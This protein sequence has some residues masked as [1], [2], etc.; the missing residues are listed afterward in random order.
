ML[1]SFSPIF[2]LICKLVLSK[3]ILSNG[4]ATTL[5]V[6]INLAWEIF[7]GPWFENH[8]FPSSFCITI[9]VGDNLLRQGSRITIINVMIFLKSQCSHSLTLGDGDLDVDALSLFG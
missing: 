7:M 6:V 9:I 3:L 1:S 4:H 8:Y 5:V 2:E